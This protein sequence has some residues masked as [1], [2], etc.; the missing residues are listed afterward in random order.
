METTEEVLGKRVYQLLQPNIDITTDID[1]LVIKRYIEELKREQRKLENEIGNLESRI[2]RAENRS[3]YIEAL[4]TDYIKELE[5]NGETNESYFKLVKL[6][7]ICGF[8]D[9]YEEY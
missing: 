1:K 4:A 3:N 6:K 8:Y 5:E 2:R 7:E 9:D